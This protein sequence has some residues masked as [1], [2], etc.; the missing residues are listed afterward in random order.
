MAR[1]KR[2]QVRSR[3][4][5]T[6]DSDFC[7]RMAQVWGE[8]EI[9]G[10]GVKALAVAG[11]HAVERAIALRE[12]EPSTTQ[13]D[14]AQP[15]DPSVFEAAARG[16]VVFVPD[17]ALLRVED[18]LGASVAHDHNFWEALLT[19][20]SSRFVD[21]YEAW[22]ASAGKRPRFDLS[23]MVPVAPRHDDPDDIPF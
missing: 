21:R 10:D 2:K 4:F 22:E 16:M 7:S 14:D 19:L 23:R 12:R 17:E 1:S 6:L 11:L 18:V 5:L 8:G 15:T 9:K 13:G 20:E 3:P